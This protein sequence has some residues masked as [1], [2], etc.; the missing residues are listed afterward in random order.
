MNKSIGMDR[1]INEIAILIF[2][3]ESLNWDICIPNHF[4]TLDCMAYNVFRLYSTHIGVF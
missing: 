4:I 3:S 2:I 1:D